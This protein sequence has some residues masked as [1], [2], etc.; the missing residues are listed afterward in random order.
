[1]AKKSGQYIKRVKNMIIDPYCDGDLLEAYPI[2]QKCLHD[3]ISDSLLLDKYIR[4]SAFVL[5][6]ESPLTKDYP[7]LKSRRAAATQETGWDGVRDHKIEVLM[8]RY[9]Y[10]SREYALIIATENTMDEY[11]E[12]VNKPLDIE[13][14]NEFIKTLDL[15][16]K[17]INHYEEL[18]EIRDRMIKKMSEG[19]EDLHVDGD[20]F[21]PNSLTVAKLTHKKVV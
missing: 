19:D 20:D 15:K 11:M 3:K 6:P 2:L 9:I 12:R 4:Y 17:L 13:D 18:I 7:D 14:E 8:L 21:I 1:M 10:R 5:D 16:K